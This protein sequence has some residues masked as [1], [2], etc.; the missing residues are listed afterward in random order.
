MNKSL[1]SKNQ[2]NTIQFLYIMLREHSREL[3]GR[4]ERDEE[5]NL[6]GGKGLG[7]GKGRCGKELLA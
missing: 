4:G 1:S 7:E 3:F 6:A 2:K 5:V